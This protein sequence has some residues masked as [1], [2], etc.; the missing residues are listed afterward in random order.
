MPKLVF[1]GTSFAIP[2]A[3]HENTHM[4]LDLDNRIVLI[5]CVNNPVVRLEQ[6]GLDLIHVSDIVLTHFHP[7]HVSGVPLFLMSSWLLGR[8]QPLNVY[9][10]SYTL[11]RMQTVMTAY[12]WE[13][14]PNFFPV[15][16]IAV[17]EKPMQ[18]LIDVED[19][20][21][22][23]SPVEH[24]IPTIG[25]RIEF[26][27]VDRVVAYSCDTQPSQ[28]VIQLAAGAD[29]LIHEASGAGFGHS[30][31]AQAAQIARQ[32]EVGRLFLIHY[33]TGTFFKDTFVDE[34]KQE[35][36]GPVQLAQDFF[37]LEF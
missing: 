23:A 5:D 7:D 26:P 29:V 18:T 37:V 12:G 22:A 17:P 6:A 2:D 10:L 33:P 27:L 16:F 20:K 32:S 25:L 11:E 3:Q 14:W 36:Q 8:E 34:A 19:L 13:S 15:N 4:A 9:G 24:M 28:A 21:I 31:A 35:F 30:S 1:L